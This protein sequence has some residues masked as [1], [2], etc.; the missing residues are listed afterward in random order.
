MSQ[1]KRIVILAVFIVLIAALS[2]DLASAE[3]CAEIAGGGSCDAGA[4]DDGSYCG[5]LAGFCECVDCTD[6][7]GDDY[8][9]DGCGDIPDCNDGDDAINPG[10][11]EV[12]D[13]EKDDN[14]DGQVDENCEPEE[15]E[16]E[17]EQ[18]EEEE[19]TANASAEEDLGLP[20]PLPVQKVVKKEE[21]VEPNY[22]IVEGDL[23]DNERIIVRSVAINK[24]IADRR[25]I[26]LG[27][28][29]VT[30]NAVFWFKVLARRFNIASYLGIA[31]VAP[32]HTGLEDIYVVSSIGE[33]TSA[34]NARAIL[35]GEEVSLM[36]VEVKDTNKPSEPIPLAMVLA[37]HDGVEDIRKVIYAQVNSSDSDAVFAYIIGAEEGPEVQINDLEIKF[38]G[39]VLKSKETFV[40]N[41]AKPYKTM[42]A[43][44][45]TTD[46]PW[47]VYLA[48]GLGI[49][50][51]ISL[52]T[53]VVY[54]LRRKPTV[55]RIAKRRRHRSSKKIAKKKSHSSKR[56]A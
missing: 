46:L 14:C 21:K 41:L 17:E 33:S 53:I 51:A 16:E 35:S 25:G 3:A 36:S 47:W 5:E 1:T 12:C 19:D 38:N 30:R 10:A 24:L 13:N 44:D 40:V 48:G 4:C 54:V 15:E 45:Y 7:D 9:V 20:V 18:P 34:N 26:A 39:K 11:S 28:D 23:S 27:V 50:L 31:S 29:A 49:T 6:G 2:S 43:N 32:E 22:V 52:T 42:T 55:K 37:E 56:K 8:Y